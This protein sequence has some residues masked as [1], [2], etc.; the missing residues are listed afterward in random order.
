MQQ[1]Y[2]LSDYAPLLSYIKNVTTALMGMEPRGFVSDLRDLLSIDARDI[3]P[4]HHGLWNYD[5]DSNECLGIHLRR[6]AKKDNN[7]NKIV[8][9]MIGLQASTS[10]KELDYGKIYD[11]I[12]SRAG[13]MSLKIN[14][15]ISRN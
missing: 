3:K 11:L 9:H 13:N 10:L 4:S 2:H 12:I 7:L 1:V 8:N 15:L 5:N 6:L 14:N